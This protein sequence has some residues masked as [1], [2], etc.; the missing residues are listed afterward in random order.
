M[1]PSPRPTVTGPREEGKSGSKEGSPV[2]PVSPMSQALCCLYSSLF[3][4]AHSSPFNCALDHCA[5]ACWTPRTPLATPFLFFCRPSHR[6]SSFITQARSLVYA[7]RIFAS[8]FLLHYFI[9]WS[10]SSLSII[11]VVLACQQDKGTGVFVLRLRAVPS[12]CLL[13]GAQLAC[14]F[15]HNNPLP[16]VLSPTT[17]SYPRQ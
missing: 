16:I 12:H 17:T 7:E 10:N 4:S 6:S 14:T 11:G 13:A 9:V 8:S 1:S 2:S 15:R 5:A 3:R